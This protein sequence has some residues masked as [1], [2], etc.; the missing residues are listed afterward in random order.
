MNLTSNKVVKLKVI[1]MN[2]KEK[3]LSCGLVCDNEYLDRY[4]EIM[5]SKSSPQKQIGVHNRHHIIPRFYFRTNEIPIDDSTENIANLVFKDHI[6][7]HYYLALCS[8]GKYRFLSELSFFR[9][10]GF[11]TIPKS[12]EAMGDMDRYDDVYRS[13]I[14]NC[15]KKMTGHVTSEETKRKISIANTGKRRTPEEKRRIAEATKAAMTD[16]MMKKNIEYHTGTI[17]VNDGVHS[18]QIRPEQI[19]EYLKLGWTRGRTKFSQAAIRNMTIANRKVAQE[20]KQKETEDRVEHTAI[21][22]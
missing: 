10:T 7:A 20:R 6:L 22:A 18:K 5:E 21:D 3:L 14:S 4:V 19:D 1:K 11:M 15:T 2:L 12:E 9:T 17:W 8:T 16:E 13:Y